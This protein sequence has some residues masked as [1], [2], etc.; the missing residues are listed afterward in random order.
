MDSGPI[1]PGFKASLSRDNIRTKIKKRVA[2]RRGY[3]LSWIL[4]FVLIMALA[5]LATDAATE[6][7]E[8]PADP[9]RI[10]P[11]SHGQQLLYTVA[12]LL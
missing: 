10:K 7:M 1:R 12:P 11:I 8:L 2:E 3:K 5:Y 4:M 9:Q 6:R